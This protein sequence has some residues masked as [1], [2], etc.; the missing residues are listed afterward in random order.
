MD[1][2]AFLGVIGL[3]VTGQ[4]AM[5]HVGLG[6]LTA[7]ADFTL[8][9]EPGTVHVNKSNIAL[10]PPEAS[11]MPRVDVQPPTTND[12]PMIMENGKLVPMDPEMQEVHHKL[13]AERARREFEANKPWRTKFSEYAAEKWTQLVSRGIPFEDEDG[14]Y[15]VP[16]PGFFFGILAAG[17][18]I[19][20]VYFFVHQSIIGSFLRY[21]KCCGC[22]YSDQ[23][24]EFDKFARDAGSWKGLFTLAFLSFWSV[25]FA[26]MCCSYKP[27]ERVVHNSAWVLNL[28]SS[29]WNLAKSIFTWEYSKTQVLGIATGT[30]GLGA[31]FWRRFGIELFFSCI[32][33]K[34]F[35]CRKVAPNQPV[36][37]A[38]RASPKQLSPEEI[39]RSISREST[40]KR[41]DANWILSSRIS[42]RP[43][44]SFAR[45]LSRNSTLDYSKELEA[46]GAVR[47]SRPSAVKADVV[48]TTPVRRTLSAVE[49]AARYAPVTNIGPAAAAKAIVP[50]K[51]V[52]NF[53]SVA[54]AIDAVD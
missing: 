49:A 10:P 26:Y 1:L 13:K 37:E 40:I 19:S 11:P 21:F 23:S 5:W 41:E 9:I 42:N 20:A 33:C 50:R 3:L 29:A 18:L 8:P 38:S 32:H 39:A 54:S 51:R 27:A 34:K 47:V 25:V 22:K 12:V 24:T 45:T 28:G 35:N 36:A 14:T 15:F 4:V 17:L 44:N 7:L 48:Q 6:G 43:F 52:A 30:F 2:I 16:L 53:S 31:A 46:N